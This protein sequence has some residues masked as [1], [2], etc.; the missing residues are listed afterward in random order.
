MA[1][2][3]PTVRFWP[4]EDYTHPED[5][6]PLERI[7]F[8]DLWERMNWYVLISQKSI[9]E[10]SKGEILSL[11]EEIRALERKLLNLVKPPFFT[12]SKIGEL[13]E[14]IMEHLS[15]LVKAGTARLG[16]FEVEITI[17]RGSKYFDKIRRESSHFNNL[18][19]DSP[20]P[21]S[22]RK[23]LT[24]HETPT[25]IPGLI[26]QMAL[27][28]GRFGDSIDRCP[29][30]SKIFLKFR[31]NAVFCGRKC[32]SVAIMR[33]KRDISNAPTQKKENFTNKQEKGKNKGGV[34]HG[35]T[36]R[37]R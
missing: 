12:I 17:R 20:N 3:K 21:K 13:Q 30:C 35:K 28:L 25:R 4:E 23:L 15:N 2:V 32:Q 27:L 8:D 10:L 24:M 36:R 7:N 6:R 14:N 11:Q 33:K 37:K 22:P 16:P 9:D 26:Y 29:H 31:S 1:I 18:M 34:S 5:V 19:K